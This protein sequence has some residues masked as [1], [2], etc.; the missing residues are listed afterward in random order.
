MKIRWS[1]TVAVIVVSL[2]GLTGGC[3]KKV[4]VAPPAPPPVKE[5]APAPPAAPTA[6]LSAEP[7]TIQPGQAVTLEWSS[8]N[9]TEA[10]IANIGPVE[11][12]GRQQV[13]PL[14]SMTYELVAT[15]PGG[16][17]RASATVI[18]VPLAAPIPTPP[19]V[20]AVSLQDRLAELSDAYFDYDKSNLRE[21]ARA[22]LEKDGEALRSILT[23]FPDVVLI[24]EGHCDERGSA[25]YNLALGERRAASASEYLTAL[26][27]QGNRLQTISYGKEKPQCTESTETCWQN[28]RRIHFAS[29]PPATN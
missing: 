28:N 1:T 14:R 17:A 2:A 9:A 12:E 10:A 4:A 18:V 13:H 16:S 22:I 8:T 7:A 11:T 25:E 20:Q 24:L 5:V 21:D 6:S 19:P 26:G 3:R 15:G 29:R 27:I 23:D